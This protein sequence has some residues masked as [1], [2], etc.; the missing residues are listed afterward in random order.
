MRSDREKLLDIMEAM[1][2][3][4]R[5]VVFGKERFETDELVQTWFIQ[6]LQIIGEA[7]RSLSQSTRDLDPTIPWK[8][9]IGMRNILAH[10]YFEIDLDLVWT[11]VY[12]NVPKLKPQ[13][14]RLLNRL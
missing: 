7:S 4:E 10:V 5:Y 1:D 3:I 6:N 8:Q 9:I 13:I 12:I 14:A 2:R 11:A